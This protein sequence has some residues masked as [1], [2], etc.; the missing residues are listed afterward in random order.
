MEP[1]KGC[2]VRGGRRFDWPSR[3]NTQTGRQASRQSDGT[4]MKDI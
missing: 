2:P 1:P 3:G 4:E